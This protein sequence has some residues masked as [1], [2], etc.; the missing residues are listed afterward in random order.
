MTKAPAPAYVAEPPRHSDWVRPTT[1]FSGK[2]GAGG[3][4]RDRRCGK[5]RNL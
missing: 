3:Q 5:T 2:G 4:S 1:S